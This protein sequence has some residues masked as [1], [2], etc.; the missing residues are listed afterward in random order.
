MVHGFGDTGQ[1]KL[2]VDEP[3]KVNEHGVV[4]QHKL[5][6][7]LLVV[8]PLKGGVAPPLITH[9][10]AGLLGLAFAPNPRPSTAIKHVGEQQGVGAIR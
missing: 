5:L 9:K 8:H 3:G 7:V 2:V 10:P 6:V 4:E 1:A